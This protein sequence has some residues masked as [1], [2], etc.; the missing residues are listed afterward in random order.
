MRKPH[1]FLSF[2]LSFILLISCSSEA[3]SPIKQELPV[4]VPNPKEEV[5]IEM[6]TA[7]SILLT[8]KSGKEVYPFKPEM[9][10][11]NVGIWTNPNYFPALDQRLLNMVEEAGMGMLRYPAGHEADL[12][13]F[14]R[15]NSS[16]WHAGTA[17]YT[18]TMR[19]D[20]LDA[21]IELCKKADAE[22]LIVVNAKIDN[23]EMAADLVRYLNVDH[24][25]KVKYFEIGNEPQ[26]WGNS[27][28]SDYADRLA[29]YAEAMKAVDP[30]IT[31]LNA[32][33]AQ[34]VSIKDWLTPVLQQAGDHVDVVNLHWYPLYDGV[35]DPKHAQY[36]AIENLLTFDY[37]TQ[38]SIWDQIGS[39]KYVD[40]FVKT[41][42]DSLINLRKQYAPEA[43]I[44][45]TEVSPVAGGNSESGVSDTMANALWFGDILG[46]MAYHGVDLLTQFLLIS[47]PQKY[48]MSDN[49]YHLRPVWYTYVMYNRYFGDRLLES[50][51]S[52]DQNLTVWASTKD[53]DEDKLYVMVINKNTAD[54][55]PAT[56]QFRDFIPSSSA[57][58][59]E[60]SSSSVSAKTASINGVSADLQVQLPTIEGTKVDQV[61]QEFTYTFPPHSITSFEFMREK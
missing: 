60:M 40:R 35:K 8:I 25:H 31:I 28:G 37:G 5:P 30:S 32:G 49:S 9:L 19:A 16:V 53:A 17:P 4:T 22:P 13:A 7:K 10:G 15:T 11:S 46:R 54:A 48:A 47:E 55:Q 51:S 50:A 45:M 34:P 20:H 18:R 38:A 43:L 57:L 61:G 6:P 3:N 12:T 42:P 23:P 56:I 14:D 44:G 24:S 21:F 33:P 58:R 41:N 29:R 2:I 27:N 52:D 59:W 36:P 39:I 1:L 26:Y